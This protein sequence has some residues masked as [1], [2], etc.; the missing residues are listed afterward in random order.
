[1]LFTDII[2]VLI[3]IFVTNAKGQ[4]LANYH[5]NTPDRIFKGDFQPA[6]YNSTYKPYGITDNTSNV[7]ICK[8]FN[9]TVGM[10]LLI[11]GKQ[12][13]IDSIL[14]YKKHVEVYLEKVI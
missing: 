4:K 6:N 14:P 13:R 3:P 12:Y 5:P 10:H 2:G 7:L 11:N 1:M 8:D 9:L